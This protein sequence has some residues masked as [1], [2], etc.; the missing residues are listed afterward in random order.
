MVEAQVEE[1]VFTDAM[2]QEAANRL[3]FEQSEW[4]GDW[5]FPGGN[6][7]KSWGEL[8]TMSLEILNTQATRLHYPDAFLSC[9]P[10]YA[11]DASAELPIGSVSGAKRVNAV[12]GEYYDFSGAMGMD[13]LMNPAKAQEIISNPPMR[14]SGGLFRMHGKDEGCMVEGSWFDW[15]C[16]AHNVLASEN[17]KNFAPSL[18]RPELKNDNY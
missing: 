15:I 11:C 7:E 8:V 10:D 9:I 1:L 13:F 14:D 17:T 5:W 2:K 6:P 16:F 18:H 12:R 4:L 3:D